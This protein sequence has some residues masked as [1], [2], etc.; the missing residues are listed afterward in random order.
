[1]LTNLTVGLLATSLVICVVVIVVNR[2]QGKLEALATV[3]PLTGV[4]NRRHFNQVIEHEMP[5]SKRYGH[6]IGFLMIDINGFK[7]IND[8]HGHQLG[9]EVLQEVARLLQQQVRESDIVVR[10]GG[11]EFLLLLIETNGRTA[12]K[13]EDVKQRILTETSLRNQTNPV[14]DFPVTFA[15]GTALWT[16]DDPRTVGEVLTEADR[17]MYEEKERLQ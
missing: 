8:R 5:R 16:A 9:D 6:S 7:E 1:M 4:Y 3:D 12:G 15:I 17:R 2:F 11:D 10:Y 14:F 13:I